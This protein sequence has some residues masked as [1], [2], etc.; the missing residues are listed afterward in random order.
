MDVRVYVDLWLN[1][2]IRA[3]CNE[4]CSACMLGFLLPLSIYLHTDFF[5]DLISSKLNNNNHLIRLPKISYF[6]YMTTSLQSHSS[7]SHKSFICNSI[8]KT[9]K[10]FFDERAGI[11]FTHFVVEA[12]DLFITLCSL[13]DVFIIHRVEWKVNSCNLRFFVKFILRRNALENLILLFFPR[14]WPLLQHLSFS[15]KFIT[16]CQS[17]K[18]CVCM[19]ST[20]MS[21]TRI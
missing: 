11:F 13:Y 16:F 18:N 2:I 6:M 15:T 7:L 17:H 14:R 5:L 10:I 3:L 1:F 21:S 8:A 4:S 9:F 12:V 20:S 19:K